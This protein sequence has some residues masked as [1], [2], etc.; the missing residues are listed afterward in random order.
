MNSIYLLGKVQ[1]VIRETPI[2]FLQNQKD[3]NSGTYK[4]FYHTLILK[5]LRDD[6]EVDFPLVSLR[7]RDE[8]ISFSEGDFVYL[9]GS[10]RT[11]LPKEDK[12]NRGIVSTVVSSNFKKINDNEVKL[13]DLE[14]QASLLRA[15]HSIHTNA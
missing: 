10:L 12:S 3:P 8:N 1:K 13:F 5:V 9:K 11:Y 7:T 6:N 14:L 4:V 15:T 2:D